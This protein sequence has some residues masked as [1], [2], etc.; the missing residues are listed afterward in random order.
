M[1][2]GTPLEVNLEEL[3]KSG[4]SFLRARANEYEFY[5]Q[6]ALAYIA[7][8]TDYAEHQC[9]MQLKADLTDRVNCVLESQDIPGMEEAVDFQHEKPIH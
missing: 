2:S 7:A 8:L 1:K 4:S 5:A 6:M 3:L 9:D